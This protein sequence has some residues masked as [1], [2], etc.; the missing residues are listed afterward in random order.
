MDYSPTT[1]QVCLALAMLVVLVGALGPKLVCRTS[2]ADQEIRERPPV[3]P[4]QR[5]VFRSTS[6]SRHALRVRESYDRMFGRWLHTPASAPET[7]PS[8]QKAA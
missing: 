2:V 1:V 5:T 6:S 8:D 7:P 4:G 3:I